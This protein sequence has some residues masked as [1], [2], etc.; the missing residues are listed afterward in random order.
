MR[1]EVLVPVVL[2]DRMDRPRRRAGVLLGA[3]LRGFV[4]RAEVHVLRIDYLPREGAI[5]ALL[6]YRLVTEAANIER[7]DSLL[8]FG[9]AVGI[10][11]PLRV[12]LHVDHAQRAAVLAVGRD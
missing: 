10:E 4:V 1:K 12:R 7:L 5:E 2:P 3:V 11:N 8:L 9:I 6:P